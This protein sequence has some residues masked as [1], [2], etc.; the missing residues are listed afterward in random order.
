[1]LLRAIW[2]GHPLHPGWVLARIF[3]QKTQKSRPP[4]SL[5]GGNFVGQLII[6]LGISHEYGPDVP[7]RRVYT[8]GGDLAVE[9][10][11]ELD[12]SPQV[13]ADPPLQHEDESEEEDDSE[14][15]QPQPELEFDDYIP[16]PHH[17]AGYAYQPQ[18]PIPDPY[19]APHPQHRPHP[20]DVRELYERLQEW[21]ITYNATQDARWTIM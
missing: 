12:L 20:A 11:L 3:R 8:V 13:A 2:E 16:S 1:I 4:S 18:V 6:S 9:Y 17:Q 19:Q 14:E 5:L 7:R 10:A 21:R 15:P